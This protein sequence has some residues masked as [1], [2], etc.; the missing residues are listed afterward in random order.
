MNTLYL[1]AAAVPVG[2]LPL[3]AADGYNR[4][5]TALVANARGPAAR[6]LKVR[7]AGEKYPPNL[8]W[9]MPAKG[10]SGCRA[11]T[12][13]FVRAPSSHLLCWLL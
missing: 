9:I 12:R 2:F 7:G 4:R 5:A 10:S 6:E 11:A 8:I 1:S 3:S 13:L